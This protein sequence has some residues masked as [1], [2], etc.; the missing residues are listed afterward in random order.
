MKEQY[1]TNFGAMP[2]NCT[3]RLGKLTVLFH[4]FKE[5]LEDIFE[6]WRRLHF[7]PVEIERSYSR[8]QFEFIGI[9]PYFTVVLPT[10]IVP[11]Y[12]VFI[13]VGKE[14]HKSTQNKYTFHIRKVGTEFESYEW[15]EIL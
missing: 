2:S 8:D 12:E 11:E 13:K 10:T 4:A 3:R 9:S 6:L 1:I 5:G 7:V 15:E 14:K